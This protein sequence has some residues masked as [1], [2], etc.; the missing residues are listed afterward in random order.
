MEAASN[1]GIAACD[2]DYIVIHDDDDSWCPDF[3]ERTVAFLDGPEGAR[4]GGVATH[5]HVRVRGNP[6]RPRHRT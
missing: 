1:A 3:L 2:S 4:Y 6:R 5:S